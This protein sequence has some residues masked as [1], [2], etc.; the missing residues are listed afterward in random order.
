MLILK[1]PKQ[2]GVTLIELLAVVVVMSVLAAIA[3]PSASVSYERKMDILQLQVQDAIDH[4]QSLSYHSGEKH[5]VRLDTSA[6]WIAVVNAVGSPVVDPLNRTPFVVRFTPAP[7][8]PT[9]AT[10]LSAKFGFDRPMILFNS[11]GDLE[12]EGDLILKAGNYQRTLSLNSATAKLT[13]TT[14][15]S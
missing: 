10:I 5:A 6:Q 7:G 9:G 8:Q 3:V 13:Q 1:K 11:K 15:G 14:I 2:A 12:Y 4:A